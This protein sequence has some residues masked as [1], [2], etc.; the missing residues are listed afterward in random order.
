MMRRPPL[1]RLVTLLAVMVLALGVIFVRLTVLQVSQ[2]ASFRD[3]AL[4]QRLRT[5][6]LPA[7]RGQILDRSREPLAIS[8]EARDVYADPRYVDDPW[9]TATT[10]APILDMEVGDLVGRLTQETSFVYLARQVDLVVAERVERLGLPG[11][12]FL[13]ATKR[14]YP[15]GSL[16]AQV[17]GFVG[18]DGEGLAGL[19]LRYEDL[20]AGD[21]GERTQELDPSGQPILGGIDVE[22]APLEGSSLVTTI[23]RDFQYQA[24]QA[25]A[26]AVAANRAQGGT[27]IV[28]DPRTG[29]ILAMASYPWFDPN[30]FD[31]ARQSTYRNRAV[32]D[33]FEPGSTN[34]VI[35]AAAAI[36][37]RAIPLEQELEVPWQMQVGDFTIH[38]AHPH[39]VMRMTLGDIIS[40]SSNIGTVMVARRLGEPAMASYLTRFGLGRTTGVSFPGESPGILPPLYDWTDTSLATIAYGQGI[41]ATPLQMI[42]VYATIAN[43]GR[44]VQPRLVLGTR[45]PDGTFEAAAPSPTRRVVSADTARMVTRMLAHAVHEGTGT[46]ATIPGFEVAGKTGTA[47]IPMPDRPGYYEGQYIASFIGYL[48]AS[49]PKVVIAAILDRPATAYGGIAAAP[50]FQRIARYAIAHLALDPGRALRPPPTASSQP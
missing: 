45:S 33:A 20:L 22:R 3:R 48:P 19:E 43:D 17:L 12:G 6:E 42:S 35:T 25:L 41:A 28:M 50:L 44:W 5:V 23:D 46:N 18:I 39:G 34:K 13:E 14:Y 7:T 37:R 21:P 9:G 30:A 27:V 15:A 8:L 29:D 16:A 32:T 2:A 31:D 40:E 26:D 10:L 38:D 24:E 1:H 36:D 11:I 49:D 4:D 47:R